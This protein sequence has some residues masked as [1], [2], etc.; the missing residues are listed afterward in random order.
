ME[1]YRNIKL[2]SCVNHNGLHQINK[3]F[4]TT[5]HQS[6]IIVIPFNENLMWPHALYTV[7][8]GRFAWW[9]KIYVPSRGG[10]T[11]KRSQ[12]VLFLQFDWIPMI[13]AWWNMDVLATCIMLML[14]SRHLVVIRKMMNKHIGTNI[15]IR[16]CSKLQNSPL[17]CWGLHWDLVNKAISTPAKSNVWSW[18]TSS[19]SY[20]QMYSDR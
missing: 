14:K 3:I 2:W 7:T 13:M 5:R 17:Y 18:L 20:V 16:I 19:K 12:L 9:R 11:R 1:C 8:P 4:E 15:M 6:P 10:K